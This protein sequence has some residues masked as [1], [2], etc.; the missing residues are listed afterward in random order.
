MALP[1]GFLDDLR[2]RTTLASVVARKVQWDAKKSNPGKGD[3]WAPCPFHQEKTASFH[4]DDRKGYY[5]CF[6]CQAKG[7]AITFVR[8]TENVGFMEAV[9]ILARE[10]GMA[11]P[12]RDPGAAERDAARAGLAEIMEIAVRYYRMALQ[13]A[14]AR[15]AR[16]YLDSRGLTAETIARFEIG[17][18]ADN[19]TALFTHLTEQGAEPARIVE[20]GLAI[21][22]DDGGAPFDRF[23]G[24]IM[25]PIRDARGR[26]IAFGGRAMSPEA[27]AKYLNSPETPLF[28]KG[29]TL[30]NHGPAREAAGK[31]GTVVVAEGYMDVIALAQAGFEH[32]VA[33]LG[34]AVTETQLALLWRMAD[35]PIIALDGDK[36]GLRAAHRLIDLALGYLAPGRSLRFALMPEGIDPDDLIRSDG[37]AAMQGVLERALPLIEL[38]WRREVEGQALD[39][40]ERRAGLDRRLRTLLAT[41]P[42]PGVRSHYEAAV[43][44]RRAALFKPAESGRQG[45]KQRGTGP[46]KGARGPT[47]A[48]RPSAGLRASALAHPSSGG[49]A[50]ARVREAALLLACFNH[51]AVALQFEETLERAP[52]L[53]PELDAMRAALLSALAAEDDPSPDGLASAV[54][55]ILGSD[56]LARLAALGRAGAT[57]HLAAHASHAQVA[58][59]L[60]ED[61]Q[62]HIALVGSDIE[63]REAERAIE[64][65]DDEGLTWRL[66]EAGRSRDDAVRGHIDNADD[67]STDADLSRRLQELIDNEIWRKNDQKSR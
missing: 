8:E 53:T 4:V 45:G 37:A 61:L 66:A 52:F 20:A 46:T 51:P 44:E 22:P 31:A 28:D 34:T 36:A 24:R 17:F 10:A 60:A 49:T 6:G 12:A 50:E 43:R 41:I 18:A 40:P 59:A 57:G 9:E 2:E 63:V 15:E 55:A 26:A 39:T 14:A 42:D 33:P 32:A 5:Y 21:Q 38:L 27:R 29:R 11:M 19:R 13:G 62:R 58:R 30:F 64:E 47:L 25:F 67:S 23:R 7:D 1:P 35:E 48:A 54:A 56:P 16:A 65:S 3:F